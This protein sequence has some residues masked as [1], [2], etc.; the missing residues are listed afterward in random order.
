MTLLNLDAGKSGIGGPLTAFGDLRVAELSPVMQGSFEYTV[1]NTDLI[2][3]TVVDGGTVTQAEA[4]AVVGTSTTTASSALLQSKQHAKYRAGL[5]GLVRFTALFTAGVAGTEQYSGILDETGSSAAFKNGFAIGFDGVDYGFHRFQNDTK[6]SINISS[7]D[8]PLNGN[9]RSGMTID[10]TKKNVFFID[11]Q[12]LGGGAIIL[13]VERQGTDTIIPVHVIDYANLNT[14]PSVHNPNFFFTIWTANKGTT[15]DMV[16]K[17][18]SYGYF[19]EGKTELLELHQPQFATGLKEKTTVTTEVAIFTIRNK[20]S[21]ASKTNFI[22]VLML[23]VAGSIEASSANNLGSVRVVKNTTLG[24]TPSYAD[25]NTSNSVIE[26]DTA[27]TDLTGGTEL[28]VMPL[29]GKNDSA[30]KD[31]DNLKVI[32]NPGETLTLA[33]TSA[34]SATIDAAGLWRELF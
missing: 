34:N 26:I 20:T 32:L 19:I 23:S 2:T 7:W 24:G 18:S 1:D 29:A 22:D 10:H 33:G 14:T 30:M 15:S 9:G 8:D 27:G 4:M 25:I 13:S 16:A 17:T 11:F 31:I 12:Y 5:G 3:K 28:F 6:I 21:Y